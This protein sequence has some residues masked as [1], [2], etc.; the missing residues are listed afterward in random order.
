MSRQH[1]KGSLQHDCDLLRTATDPEENEFLGPVHKAL[2]LNSIGEVQRLRSVLAAVAIAAQNVSLILDNPDEFKAQLQQQG[3]PDPNALQES[4]GVM[5]PVWMII[6]NTYYLRLFS[7][8]E[9]ITQFSANFSSKYGASNDA[10]VQEVIEPLN[11]LLLT[12]TD[13]YQETNHKLTLGPPIMRAESLHSHLQMVLSL[14]QGTSPLEALKIATKSMVA[15]MVGSASG[16]PTSRK[17]LYALFVAR[18]EESEL[19]ASDCE[20]L[21]FVTKVQPKACYML[22]TEFEYPKIEYQTEGD[23]DFVSHLSHLGSS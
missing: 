5:Q 8:I 11:S 23:W 16:N 10:T 12:L 7:V 1:T 2:G 9:Y 13:L 3:V 4:D 20:K 19:S 15:A 22:R 17:Q 21:S 18:E 6:A 14:N